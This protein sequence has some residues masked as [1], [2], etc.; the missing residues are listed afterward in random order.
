MILYCAIIYLN[1]L[2]YRFL[3]TI[4]TA[5]E[6]D[7][8]IRPFYDLSILA[9]GQFSTQVCDRFIDEKFPKIG[10]DSSFNNCVEYK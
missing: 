9:V 1:R 6:L 5:L 7:R 8:E 2:Q 3:G 4:R 10:E